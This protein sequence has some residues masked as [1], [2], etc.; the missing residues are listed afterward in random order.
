M[1]ALADESEDEADEEIEET[2]VDNPTVSEIEK[3][4]V[5]H[6]IY[7]NRPATKEVSFPIY[8]VLLSMQFK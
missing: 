2:D 8:P 4:D 5:S 6:T 7:P 1:K 3:P